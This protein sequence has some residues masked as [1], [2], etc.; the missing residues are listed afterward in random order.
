MTDNNVKYFREI[1]QILM[2]L[3]KANRNAKDYHRTATWHDNFASKIDGLST[4]AVDGDLVAYGASV[5]AKLRSI[6]ASL[7][8]VAV[9]VN[10]LNN[11]V[12]Y[13][14]K[15]DPGWEQVGWWTYGYKPAT[16]QVDSNLAT[17][18]EKQADAVMAGSKD[19]DTIWQMINDERARTLAVM[20]QRY[21]ESF[22]TAV[23]AKK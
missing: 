16:W 23:Q 12:V 6:A 7:R 15:I 5:S 18:R 4:L 3:T 11:A 14:T 8:G 10:T 1:D 9:D 19:R 22:A 20:V 13:N 2:D 17:I 21:G